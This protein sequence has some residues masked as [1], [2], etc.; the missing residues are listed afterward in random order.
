MLFVVNI[1]RPFTEN[2]EGIGRI[3]SEIEHSAQAKVSGLVANTHLMEHTT[4][5]T[6]YEGYEITS[7]FSEKTG[8]PL[9]FLTAMRE[10]A[11]QLDRSI[12]QCPVLPLERMLVPPFKRRIRKS[13]LYYV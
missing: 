10:L 7:K 6:L 13:P 5:Q 8:I 3:M 11:E 4:L 9:M 12:V 1:S 2:V